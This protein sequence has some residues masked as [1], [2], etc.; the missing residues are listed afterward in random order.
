MGR[1]LGCATERVADRFQSRPVEP[2]ALHASVDSPAV[3]AEFACADAMVPAFVMK[4]KELYDA[5]LPSEQDWIDEQQPRLRLG[6]AQVRE[7]AIQTGANV[8]AT[9]PMAGQVQTAVGV[10]A[11]GLCGSRGRSSVEPS[12]RCGQ[13]TDDQSTSKEMHGTNPSS[14]ASPPCADKYLVMRR[15]LGADDRA[16]WLRLASRIERRLHLTP[17]RLAVTVV[18]AFAQG[19]VGVGHLDPPANPLL[20]PGSGTAWQL[21]RLG[22]SAA[23]LL[24]S[25]WLGAAVAMGAAAEGRDA[26]PPTAPVSAT[27]T[28]STATSDQGVLDMSR[29][30]DRLMMAESGGRDTAKNPR[31]TALGP[32]QFIESTFVDV[33][34]RNFQPEIAGLTPQQ[35]LA[36][37]T[38]RPFSRRAAQAFTLENAALLAANGIAA[39]YANLRLAFLVGATAAVRILKAE[40]EAPVIGILGA[41]VVQANPFMAGMTARGL[42]LWSARSIAGGP[43]SEP[44]FPSR[45]VATAGLPAPVASAQAR[46]PA[47]P[48][49]AVKCSLRLPS[50]RRWLALAERSVQQTALKRVR[51]AGVR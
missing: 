48:R 29:F 1:G 13:K 22:R 35:I 10:E 4:D 14:T 11:R 2:S 24:T 6:R 49:I 38:D 15:N 18:A 21:G 51:R 25:F 44:E 45:V 12:C 40:P 3:R 8:V 20:V 23:C 46:V 27:E 36:L 16:R 37:R 7:S 34:S 42:S 26:S 39:N 30:L 9:E 28:E 5:L 43:S 47:K 31:S 17:R 32:F 50:C 33:V 19:V 41:A